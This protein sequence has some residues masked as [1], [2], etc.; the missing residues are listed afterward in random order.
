LGEKAGD[1]TVET[2][3]GSWNLAKQWT[4]C[5][6]YMFVSYDPGNTY[7]AEL[8]DSP[9]EDL[10]S[11]SPR[12][13]HWFFLSRQS[14]DEDRADD[15]EYLSNR[16][17]DGLAELEKDDEEL[18]APW[19]PR[20]HVVTTAAGDVDGFVGDV[21]GGSGTY[22]FAV[23][24]LQTI[25]ETG[26]YADPLSNWQTA[27]IALAAYEP[28]YFNHE[29]ERQDRLD[30][31][32]AMVL[33]VFERA[34][35][36]DPGWAGESIEADIE[37][38]DA[39]TMAQFDAL[40]IDLTLD[41]Q[42]PEFSACPAWDYIVN[43]YL[44]DVA[45]PTVCDTEIG[46]WITTYGRPGRWVHDI[47]PF[48]AM[49]SEGGTRR[50]RFYT[51]QPYL[52]TLDFRLLDTEK[53]PVPFA[54][55]FLWTGGAFNEAYDTLHPPFSFTPPDETSRVQLVVVLSGH[56]WGAEVE[57]CA[58]FC[59]HEHEFTINGD[60]TYVKDHPEAGTTYGC[61]EQTSDGVVPNQSGTWL[62]GR[63]GWCPGLEVAQWVVDITDDV[64]IGAENTIEYRG[65]F[66]GE[67][68]EPQASGSGKGFNANIDLVSYLVYSH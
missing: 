37:F 43:A 11:A 68:Y 25:R 20:L 45:D 32:G 33:R 50:V 16:I 44:C 63:G 19:P 36:E 56:G 18:A 40:E 59:N 28:T 58:E 47:S 9:L 8:L 24:R 42:G 64:T 15:V 65:L 52:L 22:S 10:L 6:S 53:E 41:C 60:A 38:P 27:R 49:L 67:T 21:L 23:D 51:Q 4:G 30:A 5:E 29:A 13:V 26:S 46:R 62:F 17:E 55:D 39:A 61:A 12:N 66:E 14:D 1:F 3:D 7:L 57:N 48:L 34:L 31:D 35:A 54:H 2:T